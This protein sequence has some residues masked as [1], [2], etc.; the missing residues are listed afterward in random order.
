MILRT[1]A[2]AKRYDTHQALRDVDLEVPEGSVFGL[3]GPNG[4]G[5]TTLLSIIAGLRRPSSGEVHLE[6][7]RGD[8]AVCP[9]APE[10]EPWLTAREVVRLA[11]SLSGR[12]PTDA[13]L[14]AL[15]KEAGLGAA[16][17]RK[18]GGFS[19]GMTQRLG[20][21]TAV[22]G[23]P[24]LVVLDE[25][26]A[27]LDP[28]GRVEV[29]DLVARF[30]SR[31]T[32]LFSSHILADVERVCDTVGVLAHGRLAYQGPLDTLLQE[33]VRP[34]WR[35]RLRGPT[36]PLLVALRATTWVRRAEEIAPA[37]VEVEAA[38]SRAGEAGLAAALAEAGVPIVAVEPVGADLETAFLDIIAAS[39]ASGGI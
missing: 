11:G 33:H 28:A 15:L 25:P 7:D 34:T 19:R 1:V 9:D 20:L 30:G 37:T 38:N 24:R 22:V 3:V 13:R 23:E 31:T 27:A 6:V 36:A 18:V 39:D 4:A 2:L 10:F 35:I 5:K 8:V 16:A 12:L 21:A 29:L 32:V 26:C 17:D 14:D